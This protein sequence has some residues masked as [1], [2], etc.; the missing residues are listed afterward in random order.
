LN[1]ER[2]HLWIVVLVPA[3]HNDRMSEL[4]QRSFPTS[5]SPGG[6]HTILGAGGVIGRELSLQ[7]ARQGRR[8]RQVSRRPVAVQAGDEW[9]SADL[10]EAGAASSAVAGSEV[11]YLVA[12][13]AYNTAIWQAQWRLVMRNVIDACARHGARLVFFD[14][15]YAYG[16]VDGVMLETTPFN[17]C[18]RKGEVRAA[19]ATTLLEAMRRGELHAMIARSA[20]FYGP[21]ANQ[22]L[23]ASVLFSRLCA[24]KAPQWIGNP[25]AAHTFTFTPDAGRA[26]AAL[27]QLPAAFGQTWH[28]P[29]ASHLGSEAVSGKA[30]SRTACTLSG[31][32][33]RLQVAPRWLL[34]AMGLFV[35]MLRENDEMLYQFE[36]DYRFDSG[37][38]EKALG[39]P[40][41]PYGEGLAQ[42]WRAARYAYT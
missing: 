22:S 38:A 10:T 41:T 39:W 34:K 37:K 35:P 24:G 9:V 8:I 3:E 13:L 1:N 33:V 18:S 19:V 21:G 31:Q 7:L 6:L 32:P 42:T 4:H 16:R 2:A 14:N 26:L 12:G 5:P 11:V 23:L 30:L 27:G 20:D 25:D 29:T 36:N 40:T 17:P 15:V 28:L